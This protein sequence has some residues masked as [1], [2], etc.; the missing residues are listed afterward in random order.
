MTTQPA[1]T[2][3]RPQLGRCEID[4]SGSTVR[5]RTRH[6]FGLA[7]VRGE[8][9]IRTGIVDVAEPL[10]ASRICVEIDAASFRTGNPQ[11]D[12]N[13]RSGRF[14]DAGRHPVMTFVSECIEATAVTGRR[15]GSTGPTSA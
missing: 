10:A 15:R 2:S 1:D 4:T 13:V 5:F 14:L 6:L 8:F 12:R 11:R 9:A 3:T 7:P